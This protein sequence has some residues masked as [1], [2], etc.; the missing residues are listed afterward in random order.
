MVF[1]RA[2]RLESHSRKSERSPQKL[3]QQ[4]VF[5]ELQSS[6]PF[7]GNREDLLA[8]AI[9]RGLGCTELQLR[10][11]GTIWGYSLPIH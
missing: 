1:I 2:R 11:R 4:S 10:P 8:I 9:R 5:I 3:A 6:F 7:S